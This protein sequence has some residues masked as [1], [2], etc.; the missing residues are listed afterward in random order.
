MNYRTRDKLS[1]VAF[2]LPALLVLALFRYGSLIFTSIISF[3]DFNLLSPSRFV[4]LANYVNAGAYDR[5]WWSL[6]HVARYAVEYIGGGLI[7]GLLL[8]LLLETKV[9]FIAF[10]RTLFFLPLVLSVAVVAWVFRLLL[11]KMHI[12]ILGDPRWALE[13]LVMIGLWQHL[14]Y[15]IL[16]YTAGLSSIDPGLYEV[17]QIDGANYARRVWHITVPLLRPVILYLSITGLIGAFQLF[18][19][20]LVLAPYGEGAGGP[21]GA[22]EVPLLLIYNQTFAYQRMGYG[23]A[24]SMILFVIILVITLIQ[25]KLGRL[26]EGAT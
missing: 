12:G 20:I 15:L 24:L 1:S 13:G 6:L 7:I 23:A 3:F 8:A 5:F 2:L 4:G 25:G 14:G 21:E 11:G 19:I 18:G 26:G 10:F 16:I 9:R 22:T 17:A